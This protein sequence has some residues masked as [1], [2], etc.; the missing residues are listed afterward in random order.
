MP[1]EV[2]LGMFDREPERVGH[3]LFREVWSNK[4]CFKIGL[5]AGQGM[6]AA[7]ICSVLND[8]STPNL[9]TAMF[10]E[11]GFRASEG[12]HTHRPVKVMLA[13]RHRTMLAGEARS[14]NLDLPEL[15]RRILV[16]IAQDRLY[17]AI[18]DQ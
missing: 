17:A 1:D 14:R 13:G 16:Q 18:L 8:G 11:W 3:P 6:T 5:M 2:Q 9:I 12:E 7:A 4:K 10:S 15:C